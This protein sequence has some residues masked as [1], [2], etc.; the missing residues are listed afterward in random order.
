MIAVV[1]IISPRQSGST[2]L[3]YLLGAHP[4]IATVGEA[5]L[6]E[7]NARCSC[8]LEY[9]ECS[10]WQTVIESM[11]RRGFAFDIRD[12][13]LEFSP[14][15]NGVSDIILRTAIRGPLLEMV[16]AAGAAVIPRA[17]RE[18]GRLLRRNEA[19]FEVVTGLKGCNVFLDSSKDASR[20]LHLRRSRK[21]DVKIIHLIRDGRANS[22]SA[23]R[24]GDRS[25]T[26]AATH[27]LAN[28]LEAERARRY[29][30]ADRWIDIRHEDLCAH[31]KET[32]TKLHAF[33]G[34]EALPDIG[35]FRS[36]QHILGN[37]RT[38]A[39]S[40]NRIVLD[41]RWQSDLT[42]TELETIESILGDLNRQYGYTPL[43]VA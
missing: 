37:S 43:V 23:M 17:R 26:D 40:D 25:A 18:L 1:S 24:N 28:H 31:P 30:T 13:D 7:G 29:F 12:P 39:A 34:V 6:P 8:G 22:W 15:G 21:L 19:F 36:G 5:R 3:T 33:I 42:S 11:D 10:F 9:E 35:D 14:G 27:W 16:R 20:T 32:L 41:Q 2:I 4:E 38:R